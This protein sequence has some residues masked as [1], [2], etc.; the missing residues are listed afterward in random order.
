MQMVFTVEQFFSSQQ[1]LKSRFVTIEHMMIL[2]ECCI[3]Q[4]TFTQMDFS[5]WIGLSHG[6]DGISVA[7]FLTY[8]FL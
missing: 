4:Q 3:W 2:P 1:S 7:V 6:N 5:K 8:L